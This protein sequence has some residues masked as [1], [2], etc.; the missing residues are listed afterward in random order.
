MM[1]LIIEE[2]ML[3]SLLLHNKKYDIVYL[4][5]EL[6]NGVKVIFE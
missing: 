2:Y 6:P 3:L 5:I 1:E 4:C